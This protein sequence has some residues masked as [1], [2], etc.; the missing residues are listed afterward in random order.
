MPVASLVGQPNRLTIFGYDAG[1]LMAA[2]MTAPA[3]RVGSFVRYAR[4][5]AFTDDGMS[6]FEAAVKWATRRE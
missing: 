4:N 5:A 6:L 3:R 2:G 1:A